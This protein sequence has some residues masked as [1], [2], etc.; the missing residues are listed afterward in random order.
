MPNEIADGP[1]ILRTKCK[2]RLH[3]QGAARGEKGT[4]TNP[5]RIK[6]VS[7]GC[8][9]ASKDAVDERDAAVAAARRRSGQPALSRLAAAASKVA[10]AAAAA[11]AASA[12]A[13]SCCWAAAAARRA[14]RTSSRDAA[15]ISASGAAGGSGAALFADAERAERVVRA[16][17]RH[18]NALRA[19]THSVATPARCHAEKCATADVAR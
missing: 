5:L 16:V 17:R 18:Y 9:I 12:A 2:H 4:A 1:A 13:S 15:S 10:A 11:A 8:P 3:S 14:E 19:G 7:L 6:L